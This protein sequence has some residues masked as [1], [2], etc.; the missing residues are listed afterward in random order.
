MPGQRSYDRQVLRQAET[1]LWQ[2]G[3]LASPQLLTDCSRATDD[4]AS[5]ADT[6]EDGRAGHNSPGRAKEQ[7]RRLWTIARLAF[8]S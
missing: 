6:T 4:H 7:R 3:S 1:P 8:P 2:C 5:R